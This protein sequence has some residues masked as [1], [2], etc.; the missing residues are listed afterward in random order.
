M[1]RKIKIPADFSLRRLLYNKRFTIPFSVIT[2][3]I[4]WLVIMINQNPDIDRTFTDI[5][6]NITLDNT[7]AAENHM[8]IIGDVSEKKFTVTI[9]GPSYVVS[10][11]KSSDFY[12]YASAAAINSPGEY[13]LEVSGARNTAITDYNIVTITPSTVSLYFDY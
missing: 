5:P 2:A 11:L 3:F 13:Q 9:N 6:L 7:Y 12:V 4:F 10:A 8:E 1:I